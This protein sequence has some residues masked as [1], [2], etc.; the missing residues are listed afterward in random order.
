MNP[1]GTPSRDF[2]RNA[3]APALGTQMMVST[4]NSLA[5]TI[6]F[7]ILRAGGNAVDAAIAAMAALGVLDP[8]QTGIGGDCFALY[9]P[10]GASRPIALNGSGPAPAAADR[11]VLSA[12]H[13][14]AI[15]TSSPDAVTIPGAVAAW[16][17]LAADHGRLGL[18]RLL[19]PA[20]ELAEHGAPVAPRLAHDWR[21]NEAKLA[22]DAGSR[23]LLLKD[24][25]APVCGT[26][27]R[28]PR[29]AATL[30]AIAAGG[31]RAF[32]EGAVAEC[33]V[34][35]LRALGG[36][37]TL[38]DFATFE[39]DYVAPVVA[40]FRGYELWQCPPNGVGLIPLM[41]ARALE[42]GPA[43]APGPL[44]PENVHRIVETG[45]MAFGARAALI[46]DPRFGDVP[47][48]RLLSDDCAAS[49]ARAV[50]PLRRTPDLTLPPLR[51]KGDTVFVAVVD[52]DGNA[53]AL[54]NS[55]FEE[56]GS[57]I[58][59]PETGV[60]FHNRG[61]GFSLAEGHPN[62]VA[63]GKRPLHTIL[64][65]MLTRGGEAVM[66]FGVT[67]GPFQPFG[68]IE[69]L[70]AMLDH[71]Y[72]LQEAMDLPR[73]FAWNDEV[74]V[75]V[76]F[77]DDA[78][79]RLAEMGHRIVPAPYALGCAQAVW[80]DRREGVLTGGSDFRRDGAAIGL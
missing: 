9:H 14:A 33:H 74:Q 57:A 29:L 12:R 10:A 60:L 77:P 53:M 27:F 42:A 45:R 39:P 64:P 25:R 35:H 50:D 46:G 72:G 40:P 67:G 26:R 52:R 6:A 30:R 61:C 4:P 51:A 21:F 1:A 63:G 7:D 5:S 49:I 68:Q 17:R 18:G 69:L 48:E 78:S 16:E 66:P 71:G 8:G 11:A 80:I 47:V 56:F 58:T 62:A 38:E 36:V 24:G 15:A 37:H 65:A 79:R 59:V 76:P 44:A 23:A 55:L 32:Y 19:A 28:Q 22:A 73:Y 34:R 41:M 3:R 70:T 43:P 2:E 75:E 20:I 31:S 54:I 13:G